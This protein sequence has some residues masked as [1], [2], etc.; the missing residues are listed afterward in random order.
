MLFDISFRNVDRRRALRLDGGA[1]VGGE[2]ARLGR[3]VEE[4]HTVHRRGVAAVVRGQH[5]SPW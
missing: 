3:R 4:P 1:P 2:G 5:P